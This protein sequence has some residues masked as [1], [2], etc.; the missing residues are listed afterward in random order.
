[1][2]KRHGGIGGGTLLGWGLGLLAAW[3]AIRSIG[4]SAAV[5]V[6]VLTGQGDLPGETNAAG[7]L[8]AVCVVCYLLART[9]ER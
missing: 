3:A 6:S 1:M 2:S 8:L 5:G 4:Y 9:Q 7:L